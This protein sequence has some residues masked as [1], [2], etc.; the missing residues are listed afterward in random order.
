MYLRYVSPN[1]PRLAVRTVGL[2]GL[3]DSNGRAFRRSPEGPGPLL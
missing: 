1:C 2:K 3:K